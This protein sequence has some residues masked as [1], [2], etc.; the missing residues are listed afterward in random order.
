[1]TILSLQRR[2]AEVGRIR[3]GQQ[4]ESSSGKA[5]PVKLATFRLTSRDR[6]RIDE[7]ARL[8]GGDVG[9]WES[10]S[11][12]QW[13]VVTDTDTLDVIVPPADM[14]FTQA[15]EMWGS[16]GCLRRCDGVSESLSDGPCL[17][18]P[19]ARECAIHT[20]LSVM[21]RDL[22][23]LGVWR[24][25]TSGYYAAVELAAAVQVIEAAAGAGVMLPARLRLEQRSVKRQG[26]PTYRFAVPVLDVDIS[27]GEL[28]SGGGGVRVA[29]RLPSGLAEI[30]SGQVGNGNLTPV[31]A[32]VPERPVPSV[33]EQAAEVEQDRAKPKRRN[34]AE[35]IR[36]TGLR[37]RTAAEAAEAAVEPSADDWR[38]QEW[39]GEQNRKLRALYKLH[40]IDDVTAKAF[41]AARLGV[42]SH[43]ELTRGQASDLIDWLERHGEGAAETLR[44][45]ALEHLERD[46]D[47][48]RDGDGDGGDG[49]DWRGIAAELGLHGN[50][51][52]AVAREVA[53]SLGVGEPQRLDD[54]DGMDHPGWS[55]ALLQ[56]LEQR[57]K[58]S[59]D[60]RSEGVGG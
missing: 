13:E 28:L 10:P 8:Y 49:P 33:A 20:R 46:A 43:S 42:A 40:H 18:D 17:C 19:D 45:V 55:A 22:P 29:G 26:Q 9:P 34:A 12:G 51:V 53:R 5:R 32:S 39:T 56:A 31:P 1:M 15:Y 35:P 27:P 37:P 14:A 41:L 59:R 25:D 52:V 2:L 54:L 6:R 60:S 7:A 30:E 44:T 23:G 11:G 50:T 36:A 47:A 4:V 57:A 58:E 48:D 16:G 24:V 38:G 21:L 3:L